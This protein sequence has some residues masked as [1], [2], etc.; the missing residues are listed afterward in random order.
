MLSGKRIL[1]VDDSA[2]VRKFLRTLLARDGVEVMDEAST[3]EETIRLVNS[4]PE[5][6]LLL[7]DLI[8]PDTDGIQVLR[9]VR[10]INQRCAVVVI[11]GA[12]GIKTATLAVRQGADGYIG[13]QDLTFGNDPS[14]FLF[15]L[16]QALER[17]E[18]LIAQKELEAF[19]AEFY[20]MIT[21][22]LRS[23]TGSVL[24]CAEMLLRGDAGPL[25][26]EQ[27]EVVTIAGNSARKLLNLINNYLDY[28]KID[29]GFLRLE[30]GE[31]DLRSLVQNGAQF[32]R[33]QANAKDVSL[34]LDLPD[35]PILA[36]AD[37]ERLKQVL[38]NLISN[39]IKYTPPGGQITVQL[40]DDLARAQA[41]FRI[42]DTG[43]GIPADQ[44]PDLFTRYHRAPGQATRSAPGTGLGLLIVKEI[45]GA[46]GG[47][48]SVQSEGLGQGTTF[49]V[50]LP[51][52]HP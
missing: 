11:T 13:K 29:A 6:D 19:K 12:G 34:T 7:L 27:T 26:P 48:V 15:A 23:P 17:R 5:Y 50:T 37:G 25:T 52:Q 30:V 36:Q 43:Y 39:S 46:H 49:L 21:H 28:A 4:R 20:S 40:S 33:I 14:D 2:T 1:I 8:L 35:H 42:S 10:K 51:L 32:A 45:V 31:V 41:V 47:T 3:G 44:L 18:G 38:D 22:D 24:L 16:E 9:Q